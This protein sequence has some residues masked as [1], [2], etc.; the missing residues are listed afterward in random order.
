MLCEVHVFVR[1]LTNKYCVVQV[2]GYVYVLGSYLSAFDMMAM[3]GVCTPISLCLCAQ[4]IITSLMLRS[5]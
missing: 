4:E 3:F 2:S 1:V 5:S